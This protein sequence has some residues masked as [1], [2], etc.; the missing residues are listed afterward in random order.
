M[1]PSPKNRCTPSSTPPVPH[2]PK[3]PSPKGRCTPSSTPPVPYLPKSPS[4]K[5]RCTPSSTPPV[6]ALQRPY[7]R[8][9][10]DSLRTSRKAF[11]A[12]SAPVLVNKRSPTVEKESEDEAWINLLCRKL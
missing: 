6:P 7:P 11:L 5:D 2:L 9:D 3:S 10:R 8:N 4:L 12:I 1:G